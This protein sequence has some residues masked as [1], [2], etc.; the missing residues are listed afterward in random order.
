MPTDS[1]GTTRY[2]FAFAS[3]YRPAALVFGVVPATTWAELGPDGLRV[4]FGP[5]RLQTGLHNI[6]GAERSGGFGWLKTAGPAHLS[7]SDGGSLSPPT[8]TTRSAFASTARCRASTPP[9]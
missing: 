5:W 9:G 1:S 8:G 4:R 7:F 6:A 2:D 3:T